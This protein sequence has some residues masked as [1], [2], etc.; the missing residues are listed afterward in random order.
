MATASPL[1]GSPACSCA[2]SSAR[3]P[4]PRRKAARAGDAPVGERAV[5]F[6][7]PRIIAG[8]PVQDGLTF[9]R[10]PLS[11]ARQGFAPEGACNR[12]CTAVK[13]LSCTLRSQIGRAHV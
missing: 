9:G 11:E 5:A 1:A 10:Q 6:I 12:L 13:L 4:I 3:R 8:G 2:N 7:Q